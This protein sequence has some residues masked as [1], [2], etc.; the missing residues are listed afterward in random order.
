MKKI[1]MLFTSMIVGFSLCFAEVKKEIIFNYSKNAPETY[2]YDTDDYGQ[3]DYFVEFVKSYNEPRITWSGYTYEYVQTMNMGKF[4]IDHG[5][6]RDEIFLDYK[7]LMLDVEEKRCVVE[8][9]L[10]EGNIMIMRCWK[11][12]EAK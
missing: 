6:V 5:N 12:K 7:Y 10:C 11:Y 1:I 2:Y 8:V 4:M 3:Q 9:F